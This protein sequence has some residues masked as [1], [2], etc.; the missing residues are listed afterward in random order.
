MRRKDRLI[1]LLDPPFGTSELQPGSIKGHVPGVQKN[2][3]LDVPAA[4][5]VAPRTQAGG[6][7]TAYFTLPSRALEGVHAPL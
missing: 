2:G 6:Q 1:Q 4:R 5:G 7:Y 3:G